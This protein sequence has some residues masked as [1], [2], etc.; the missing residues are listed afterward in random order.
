MDRQDAGRR[1]RLGM[2][3]AALAEAMQTAQAAGEERLYLD[4]RMDL[5]QAALGAATPEAAGHS[6]G[7]TDDDP[8]VLEL[9]DENFDVMGAWSRA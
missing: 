3:M 6:A 5:V 1:L 2:P 8:V 7:G 9:D 4:V